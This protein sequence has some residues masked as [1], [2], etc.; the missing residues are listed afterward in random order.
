MWFWHQVFGLVLG[1]AS[2]LAWGLSVVFLV[3]TLRTLMIKPSLAQVRAGHRMQAIVP[4]LR[5]GSPL[6]RSRSVSTRY[7]GRLHSTLQFG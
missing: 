7:G 6:R 3:L 4:L 2:G 5:V 1:P